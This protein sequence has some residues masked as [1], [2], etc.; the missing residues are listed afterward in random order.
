MYFVEK[1][2]D[3]LSLKMTYYMRKVENCQLSVKL[4]QLWNERLALSQRNF[5]E[6]VS[7]NLL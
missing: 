2:E 5:G 3:Y 4:E 6:A 7:I 1:C